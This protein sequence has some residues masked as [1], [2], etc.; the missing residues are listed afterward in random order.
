M[1]KVSLA[2]LFD[3]GNFHMDFSKLTTAEKALFGSG[4]VFVLSTFL[5][6]F[7]LGDDLQLLGIDYSVSGW[8]VGFLWGPLPALI[9]LGILAWVGL[10]R[11][12]TV[13]LPDDI[14]PLYL[15]G[16]LACALPA[17]KF[18]IGVNSFSRGF[19]LILAILSGGAFAFASFLKF[20]ESG[21]KVD[22]IKGQLSGMA[23]QLGDKAKGAVTSAQEAAKN[24]KNPDSL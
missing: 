20:I 12:S 13:A 23:D 14:A 3:T 15:G 24:P 11:F 8:D 2:Q 4:I 10:K 17:L 9:A 21:G 5:T 18:L 22:E 6:W 16:V 1:L 7:K 19:G